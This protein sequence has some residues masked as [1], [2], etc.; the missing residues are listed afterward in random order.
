MSSL[1]GKVVAITGGAS[2]IGLSTARLLASR[3]V[4]LSLADNREDALAAAAQE[5]R[6]AGGMVITKV[7][8]V[9]D[10]LQ[11]DSWIDATMKEY[12]KLDGA[13]N[14]AGV[15][16]KSIGKKGIKDLDDQEWDFVLGVNMTGVFYCLRAELQQI[17][18]GG[19]IVNVASIAG[20]MGFPYNAPYST[21]KHAVIGMT[22]CAAKEEGHRGVR[23][24][25]IAPGT[26]ST[27]MVTEATELIGQEQGITWPIPRR[28]EPQEVAKLVAFLL[29]DDSSFITGAT[30]SIDGGWGC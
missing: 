11:V 30:Y 12:G 28:G 9:R 16:G 10:R 21:S 3:G 17:S 14:F 7:T 29:S 25:V 19:S 2:G 6:S 23:V 1:E 27:P 4:L 13:C 20:V 18:K 22:R 26:I 24:N 15:I 8:N 5:I